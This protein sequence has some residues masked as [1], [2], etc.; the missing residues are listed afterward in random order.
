[1]AT[2]FKITQSR[3]DLIATGGIAMVSLAEW[4]SWLGKCGQADNGSYQKRLDI[5]QWNNQVR[6]R[7]VHAWAQ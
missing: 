6:G 7:S 4:Q 2:R 1:M 5:Q 3:E